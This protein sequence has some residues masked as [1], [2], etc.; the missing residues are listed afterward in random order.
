[1]TQLT[2]VSTKPDHLSDGAW[3]L[4][5]AEAYFA[6]EVDDGHYTCSNL[7]AAVFIDVQS[8]KFVTTII[9]NDESNRDALSS[10]TNS[11]EKLHNLI[12]A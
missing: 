5:L 2:K 1:M 3:L 9:F 11:F 12:T 6:R 7:Y 4:R 10:I 8:A